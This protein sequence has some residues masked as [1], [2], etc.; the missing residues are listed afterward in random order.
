[1]NRKNKIKIK[2]YLLEVD[3]AQNIRKNKA[4][5]ADFNKNTR[6]FQLGKIVVLASVEALDKKLSK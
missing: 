2:L 3:N 4:M 1:M 5:K 6:F